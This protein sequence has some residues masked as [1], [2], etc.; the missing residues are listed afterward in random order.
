MHTGC[1]CAL[2]TVHS[3]AAAWQASFEAAVMTA[4]LCSHLLCPCQTLCELHC[5]KQPL[6]LLPS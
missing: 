4:P 1:C 6:F 2:H 3:V 5:S